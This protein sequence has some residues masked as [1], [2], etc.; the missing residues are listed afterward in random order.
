MAR[1]KV[2][3][4]DRVEVVYG[5]NSQNFIPDGGNYVVEAQGYQIRATK[6]DER[7]WPMKDWTMVQ[8]NF[9]VRVY[10]ALG[11]SKI[12]AN[13]DEPVGKTFFFAVNV[14]TKRHASYA[15]EMTNRDGKVQKVSDIGKQQLAQ[16]LSAFG[17]EIEAGGEYDD[18]DIPGKKAIWNVW[19][20]DQKNSDGTPMLDTQTG[21]VRREMHI[22]ASP[23]EDED[24]AR[25]A[26]PV[27]PAKA[28]KAAKA[29]P[30]AVKPVKAKRTRTPKGDEVEDY[31]LN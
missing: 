24:E 6:K 19:Y 26:E 10:E 14:M 20:K 27:K 30:N 2:E 3:R 21:E 16:I 4:L 29:E 5:G 22:A 12:Q 8:H 18:E 31:G 9:R 13:G 11:K 23:Y 1:V 25:T 7:D 15:N 17:V 28:A